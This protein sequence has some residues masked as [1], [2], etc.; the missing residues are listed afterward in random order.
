MLG[1]V[2]KGTVQVRDTASLR[3]VREWKLGA[4]PLYF[5]PVADHFSLA[6]APAGNLLA[7]PAGHGYLALWDWTRGTL[8]RK[9][10]IPANAGD[11]LAFS[12]DAEM[13][14]ILSP[15]GRTRLWD[16]RTGKER[17]PAEGHHASI[18]SLRFL[19]RNTLF[20]GE[21]DGTALTWDLRTG[22]VLRSLSRHRGLASNSPDGK[23]IAID[24]IFDGGFRLADGETGKTIS[25]LEGTKGGTLLGP[26]TGPHAFSSDSRLFAGS[27][28]KGVIQVRRAATG[29]ESFRLGKPTEGRAVTSLAF[30]TDGRL[31]AAS[32]LPDVVEVWD[33]TRRRL[34]RRIV[35]PEFV[36]RDAFPRLA[37]PECSVAFTPDGKSVAAACATGPV[38]L[39]NVESGRQLLRSAP[40]PDRFMSTSAVSCS[41]DGRF[42]AVAEWSQDRSIVLWEIASGCEVAR[43]HPTG[44]RGVHALAFSPD[45]RTLAS[46]GDDPTILLWKVPDLSRRR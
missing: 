15:H 13:L 38:R 3:L 5:T 18:H 11:T 24:S 23:V 37:P 45:G 33:T 25:R 39:W 41:P 44:G 29:E 10:A 19:D 46:G 27:L 7:A 35:V 32:V 2:E 43:F 20:S 21:R 22:R 17:S 31:L 9:L 4:D 30:S 36:P 14:A 16:V 28:S 8:I 1:S 6:F 12:P 40:D 42:V 26:L 34:A